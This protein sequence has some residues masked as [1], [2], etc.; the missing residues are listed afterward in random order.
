MSNK[1]E[2]RDFVQLK[3]PDTILKHKKHIFKFELIELD[4]NI[5]VNCFCWTC[6]ENLGRISLIFVL[7]NLG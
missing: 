5:Y 1:Q 7:R 4:M 2:K 3:V 6:N